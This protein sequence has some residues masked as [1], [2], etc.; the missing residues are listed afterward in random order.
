[1]LLGSCTVADLLLLASLC[2]NE[3]YN[4]STKS[5]TACV[6]LRVFVFTCSQWQLHDP[7]GTTLELTTERLSPNSQE[8]PLPL[9]KED[10][11]TVATHEN[12]KLS[13][14][15]KHLVEAQKFAPNT[16]ERGRI[17]LQTFSEKPVGRHT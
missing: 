14:A 4:K 16:R 15:R 6:S 10:V 7:S 11:A 13:L 9:N 8:A 5:T 12:P 2:V 17:M 3:I 1:M